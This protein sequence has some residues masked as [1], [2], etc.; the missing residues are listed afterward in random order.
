MICDEAFRTEIAGRA[1]S[2]GEDRVALG[3]RLDPWQ[4]VAGR[5]ERPW[6]RRMAAA[7]LG[8]PRR[9]IVC[10]EIGDAPAGDGRPAARAGS[11]SKRAFPT[12]HRRRSGARSNRGANGR[13]A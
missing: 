2:R 12:A 4:H 7:L 10:G 13:T 1:A 5:I 9:R 3:C 6:R 11:L 8:F